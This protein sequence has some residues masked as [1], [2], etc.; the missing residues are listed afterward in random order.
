MVGEQCVDHARDVAQLAVMRQPAPP[1]DDPVLG[2]VAKAEVVAAE[3]RE[4]EQLRQARAGE[5]GVVVVPVANHR[6]AEAVRG[7]RKLQRHVRPVA[8]RP[9][10]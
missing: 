5:H 1:V 7:H 6:V 10:E 9:I 3:R 8:G 4:G 2:R